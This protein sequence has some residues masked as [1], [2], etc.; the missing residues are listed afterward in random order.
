M[1]GIRKQINRIDKEIEKDGR[2]ERMSVGWWML[3]S[4]GLSDTCGIDCTSSADV[5]VLADA[6]THC[7]GGIA[8]EENTCMGEGRCGGLAGCR[9]CVCLV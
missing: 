3:R 9:S 1:Q 8:S 7:S 4:T 2:E 5:V 6:A